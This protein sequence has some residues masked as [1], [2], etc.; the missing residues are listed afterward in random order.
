MNR[1]TRRIRVPRTAWTLGCGAAGGAVFSVVGLPL[2][3]LLGGI[4]G[5]A[6]AASAG[7]PAGLPGW[8]R[9]LVLVLLGLMIGSTVHH[10][11]LAEMSRWPISM[12][13]VAGYVAVTTASTRLILRR[14]ARFDAATAYFAA[15]P[16][17]FMAMATIGD[18]FG[19][20]ARGIA[21]THAMRVVLVLFTLVLGYHALAGP[22]TGGGVSDAGAQSVLSGVAIA[23]LVS[24][25]G[26]GWLLARLLRVPASAMIGPLVLMAVAKLSSLALPRPPGDLLVLAEWVLGSGIGADFAGVGLAELVRGAAV[27]VAATLWMLLMSVAFALALVPLTDQSP[28]SL[29]LA[30]SPGGLS[31]VSMVALALGIDP[32]FVTAHNVFRVLLILIVAPVVFRLAGGSRND[33][34]SAPG[35]APQ[36]RP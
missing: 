24:L 29:L 30:L 33:T 13:G 34:E 14:L 18:T 16:G 11:T 4:V 3:W 36:R 1:E 10:D 12:A 31:G 5:S 8:L 22:T 19:G 25:G 27:S 6:A 2:P 32:A 26:G 15:A 28:A 35:K 7:L 21:L 17:G 23:Q 20:Q 9:N